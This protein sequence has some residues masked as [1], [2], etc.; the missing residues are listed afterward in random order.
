[1]WRDYL[2]VHI[3]RAVMDAVLALIEQERNGETIETKLINI[4]KDSFGKHTSVLSLLVY[5]YTLL[6][7]H[8]YSFISDTWSRGN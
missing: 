1:M 7:N 5:D 3:H 2:F 4:V 8:S 6:T